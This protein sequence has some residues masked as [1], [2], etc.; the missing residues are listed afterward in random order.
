MV[1][2][3]FART[4]QYPEAV[5]KTRIHAMHNVWTDRKSTVYSFPLIKII[6]ASS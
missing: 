1:V 5:A 4:S 3:A 2:E 6:W